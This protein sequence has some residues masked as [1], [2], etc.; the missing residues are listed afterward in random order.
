MADPAHAPPAGRRAKIGL[1]L[2]GGAVR[3]AAHVGVLQVLE[4]E[5][6]HP[7]LIAGTSVGSIVGAACAAG[8]A[9]DD[10]GEI[11]RSSRWPKM[12]RLSIRGKF[13]LFDTRPMQKTLAD[14]LGVTTF[15][16]LSIPFA[17]ISCDLI[18]G[19]K[20][21]FRSGHLP[22]ALRASSA[23]PGI[24]PPVESGGRL[25]V[26]GCVV[27]N[28]PVDVVRRMGADYVIAVDLIPPP[29]GKHAPKNY[30][31]LMV[32]AGYLWSRANHPDPSTIDCHIVPQVSEYLGWDFRTAPEI[33][34]LGRSAAEAVLPRLTAEL[35][36]LSAG[37][38]RCRP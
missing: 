36:A 23:V 10:I 34:A 35:A 37:E 21:I 32:V 24:F 20:V 29:S 4:R 18:T 38:E 33:E 13:S 5:G 8:L 1:A 11:F 25:L 3:G 6:I 31:E 9:A 17:A 7:D 27:D 16:E 12:A 2:S 30:L 26:D 14:H 28:L 19:Q 22:T 15:E